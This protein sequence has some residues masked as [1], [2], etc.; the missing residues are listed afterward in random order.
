MKLISFL[1]FLVLPAFVG[2]KNSI[3]KN[4]VD[5]IILNPSVASQ[6]ELLS[7]TKEA[8][9]RSHIVLADN[10]LTT[11]SILIIDR[12]LKNDLS[13]DYAMGRRFDQPIKFRL[14]KKNGQCIL[15][16]ENTDKYW[17]LQQ[18]QCAVKP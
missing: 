5:A 3:T 12:D 18:T 14:L 16:Q 9:N 13:G 1:V 7:V 6:E 2:C 15:I 17:V 11:D 4:A 8:L 10:A